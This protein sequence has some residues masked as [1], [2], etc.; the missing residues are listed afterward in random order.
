MTPAA[1]AAW[2]RLID[3]GAYARMKPAP[4]RVL[5][6]LLDVHGVGT[7]FRI[8]IG[9]LAASA[10]LSCR[11]TSQALRALEAGGFVFRVFAELDPAPW[12]VI[13]GPGWGPDCTGNPDPVDE[14]RARDGGPYKR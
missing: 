1:A 13:D 6:Y 8:L 2:H 12:Y 10:G 9:G 11:H 3:S 4:L 14:A 5:G 7:R